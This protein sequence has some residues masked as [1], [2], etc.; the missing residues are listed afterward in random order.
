MIGSARRLVGYISWTYEQMD[1]SS[2][3]PSSSS[4]NCLS[5]DAENYESSFG[6]TK[7]TARLDAQARAKEWN[8]SQKAK[9]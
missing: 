9:K 3:I 8:E 4:S 6:P 1:N 2:I 5:D 7:K